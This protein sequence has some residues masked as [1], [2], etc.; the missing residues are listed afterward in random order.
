MWRGPGR[1][2]QH[3]VGHHETA[4]HC[5]GVAGDRGWGS[6]RN[7]G[8][9]TRFYSRSRCRKCSGVGE[10]DGVRPRNEGA[11]SATKRLAYLR[12]GNLRIVKPDH[13]NLMLLGFH[14]RAI[15]WH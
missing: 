13:S 11:M 2:A 1:V 14:F 12:L 5:G 7:D 3:C 15:Q 6:V 4:R 8:E 10:K 9:P